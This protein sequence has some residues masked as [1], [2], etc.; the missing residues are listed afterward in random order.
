MGASLRAIQHLLRE[1][2]ADWSADHAPRLA[3]ALSYYTLFSLAPL[4]V[5][6]IAV[7][8]L[9]FGPDA[10]RGELV[11]QI[12]GLV[13]RDGARAI[14]DLIAS[15]S[16]PSDG[17]LAAAVGLVLLLFGAGGVL[18]QLQDA[19]NTIWEV[20][21]PRQTGVWT[22]IRTRLASFAFVLGIGFMLL[23]SLAVSAS[24]AAMQR[25][26]SSLIPG[27]EV[28]WMAVN[29][30][31]SVVIITV[32][33]ALMFKYVPDA[34]I[35]WSDVWIGAAA[36]AILFTIGKFLVGMY[37]GRG[38]VASAYGAAGSLVVVLVWVYYSA[39]I[40]FFGAELTQVYARTYGSRIRSRA[41]S[42]QAVEQGAG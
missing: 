9:V 34:V 11:A 10:V 40:L 5:I 18:L 30:V 16:Q 39:Q 37:L 13:G 33:F 24:L 29:F 6:V 21:P 3:A 36:T 28:V 26:A 4:L 25:Y 42:L 12:D 1:T 32:L 38:S 27:T 23:V 22:F 7:A 19:L 20:Q 2:L 17:I 35:R 31:S 14:E 41:A 8:G 15:A